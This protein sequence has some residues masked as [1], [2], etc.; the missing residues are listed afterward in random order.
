[1]LSHILHQAIEHGSRD[2]DRILEQVRQQAIAGKPDHILHKLAPVGNTV[3]V[4]YLHVRRNSRKRLGTAVAVVGSGVQPD[5]VAVGFQLLQKR[6]GGI[7]GRKVGIRVPAKRVPVRILLPHAG[8]HGADCRVG[9]RVQRQV[10]VKQRKAGQG[11]KKVRIVLRHIAVVVVIKAIQHEHHRVSAARDA[12]QPRI[13]QV[14][15]LR[16][17][18]FPVAVAILVLVLVL[19]LVVARLFPALPVFLFPGIQRIQPDAIPGRPGRRRFGCRACGGRCAGGSIVLCEHLAENRHTA[20]DLH[21]QHDY[22]RDT[23]SRPYPALTLHVQR[24]EHGGNTG[25]NPQGGIQ[26]IQP[27]GRI[28]C[29]A[30][31]QQ[32]FQPDVE[33][34]TLRIPHHTEPEHYG[35]NDGGH[36]PRRQGYER[37]EEHRP[38]Q[39]QCQ[40]PATHIREGKQEF[41]AVTRIN[42]HRCEQEQGEG[43]CRRT[44]KC[45]R[46]TPHDLLT[47]GNAFLLSFRHHNALAYRRASSAAFI[48]S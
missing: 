29:A 13:R 36:P 26:Y 5:L 20:H 2:M 31:P 32:G 28:P 35:G 18:L 1:M 37:A 25:G 39:R 34:H 43:Q 47:V 17:G 23:G 42:V 21:A 7:G 8:Y 10:V 9:T 6:R 15:L 30:V 44:Q 16:A 14:N 4:R 24:T 38:D 11:R 12:V 40:Q 33:E 3:A 45:Q 46:K 41:R 19:V 22:Q 27:Q 48:S